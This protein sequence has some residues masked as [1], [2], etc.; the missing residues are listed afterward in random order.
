MEVRPLGGFSV[1]EQVVGRVRDRCPLA[2]VCCLR[3]AGRRRDSS[4]GVQP[5]DEGG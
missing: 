1:V 5:L 4:N 3:T 2:D